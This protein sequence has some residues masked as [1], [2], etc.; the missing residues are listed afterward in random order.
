MLFEDDL[1]ERVET[2]IAHP[3]RRRAVLL[4]DFRQMGV[5][6]GQETHALSEDVFTQD[7][8][9]DLHGTMNRDSR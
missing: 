8:L 1:D 5:A 6:I 4:H 2:G 7:D 9:R 3:Q